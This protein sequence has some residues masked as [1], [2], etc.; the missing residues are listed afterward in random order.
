[1]AAQKGDV[2]VLDYVLKLKD[3]G[4]VIDTTLEEVAKESGIY[5]EGTKYEP[6]VV[7]LGEGRLIQG[8]EEAV[9]GME[10]GQEKEV[11]I[12]PEKAFGPRDPSKIRRYTVNEFRK[13]GIRNVYPG[14]VVEIGNNVGVVK[15]VSG[16]RV[17]VDFNH[18]YAGKTLVAKIILK[19]IIKDEK[20]KIKALVKRRMKD[21]EVEISDGKVVIKVPEKYLLAEG[22]QLAKL[23]IVN[24]LFRYTNVK[25]VAFIE[26]IKKREEKAETQESQES[27]S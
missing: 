23:S 18:P 8:I 10:K 17:I 1:M 27:S 2:V 16:G 19:D 4:E 11:E 6:F 15:A 14:M 24:D 22:L 9:E 13:A 20:E 21:A 26:E 3:T 25:E 5:K 12:P 7:V